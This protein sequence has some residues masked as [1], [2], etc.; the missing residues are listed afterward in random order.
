MEHM[1]SL[2]FELHDI[3]MYTK[4]DLDTQLYNPGSG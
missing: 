2:E 3:Y 4:I 1:C